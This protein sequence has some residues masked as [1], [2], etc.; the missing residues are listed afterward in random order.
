MSIFFVT[1]VSLCTRKTYLHRICSPKVQCHQIANF[2]HGV[3]MKCELHDDLR[4]DGVAPGVELL[5]TSD[6]M[7]FL[8]NG[9]YKYHR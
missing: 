8:D 5:V 1:F 9:V 7:S 6:I 4:W 2:Y 3:G